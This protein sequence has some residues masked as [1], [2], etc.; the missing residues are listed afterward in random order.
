MATRSR[1]RR[2]Q[3]ESNGGRRRKL[4]ADVP[5]LLQRG[6][7]AH[8]AGDLAAAERAYQAVLSRAPD[9]FDAVHLRGVVLLQSGRPELA[10]ASISRALQIDSTSAAAHN[11]LGT[12]YCNVEMWEEAAAAYRRAADLAPDVVDHWKNLGRVEASAGNWT[13]ALE[14]F[15][16]AQQMAPHDPETNSAIRELRSQLP[17]D[18]VAEPTASTSELPTLTDAVER[19]RELRRAGRIVAG[20]ECLEAA[21]SNAQHTDGR[22]AALFELGKLCDELGDLTASW[23]YWRQANELA[24]SE[25][26]GRAEPQQRLDDITNHLL[27]LPS[28][29]VSLRGGHSDDESKTSEPPRFVIGFPRTGTTLVAQILDSH[30]QVRTLQEQPLLSDLR[31]RL[32]QTPAGYPQSLWELEPQQRRS[33]QSSY[34]QAFDGQ[35]RCDG[36]VMVDVSADHVL[37]AG[38]ARTVFPDAPMMFLTRHPL[39]I[40]LSCWMQDFAPNNLTMNLTSLEETCRIYIRTMELWERWLKVFP[41]PILEIRYEDLARNPRHS[42]EVICSF[43]R[44]SFEPSML[45]FHEHANRQRIATVSRDQV[46]R[47]MSVSAIGRWRGY[48]PQLASVRPLLE[49]WI[50]RFG[51]SSD[52]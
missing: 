25:L 35:S 28:G 38:V 46:R 42:V 37:F 19:A 33:L 48:E 22:R 24:K 1:K 15:G 29:P 2:T 26:S 49:P 31:Q 21:L 50:E 43:L 40:C 45:R 7:A 9:H 23:G 10:I 6:L 51:Y 13:S 30:S 34:R 16:Q 32:Q 4:A 14:C 41:A 52:D 27:T 44:I 8:Q 39:D 3:Q 18:T 12:A 36:E 47:P 20:R 5:R 17:A 11:N